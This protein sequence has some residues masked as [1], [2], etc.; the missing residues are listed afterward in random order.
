M[1]GVHFGSGHT[2]DHQVRRVIL[3]EGAANVAVLLLKVG[4]AL[5]TGSVAILADAMHSLTDVANNFLAWFVSRASTQPP[6]RKHPYGHRKFETLAVFVLATLLTVLAIELVLHA[7]RREPTPIVQ[8]PIGLAVMALVLLI[9]VGLA[10]WE[11]RWAERLDSPILHADSTHT[12][13]DVLTTVAVI[14]GWQLSA[15]GYRWMDTVC[16]VG[17]AGLVLYLAFGLYSRVVPVLVDEMSVDPDTLTESVQAT[18]GVR[19]VRRVRSRWQGNAR[20]VDMVI[21]V[22]PHLPTIR[23]HDVADAVEQML[24]E[25]YQVTDV[26]IHIEPHENDK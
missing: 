8:T 18:D 9:N 2:R 14:I 7:W 1:S 11:R 24:Q 25:Q 17:V 23:A 12:L 16:A 15:M 21:T 5:A 4:V 22:D 3:V 20:A 10:A 26:S 6:D 19:D 13:V